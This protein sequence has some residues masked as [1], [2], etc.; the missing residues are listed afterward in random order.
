VSPFCWQNDGDEHTPFEQ[1]CEQH[2]E[3]W[4]HAFPTLAPQLGLIGVQ[5]PPDPQMPL[6][7]CM[8]PAHPRPSDVH[9]GNWHEP[10][11]HVPLQQ[12]LG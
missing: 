3:F 10:P 2:C 6:Q 8:L 7:H 5:V 11:V 4:V 12:S 9:A 1:N